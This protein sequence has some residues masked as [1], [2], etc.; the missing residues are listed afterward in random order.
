MATITADPLQFLT[1]LTV[2][3]N[4]RAVGVIRTARALTF[5]TDVGVTI[6]PAASDD[7]WS[8]VLIDR[9]TGDRVCQVPIQSLGT[10][11]ETLN[12]A[13]QIPLSLVWDGDEQSARAL[14]EINA[15]KF[16]EL[17]VRRGRRVW[18]WGVITDTDTD[19][20]TD[21]RQA[22]GPL[23]YFDHRLFGP[24]PRTN[25]IVNGDFTGRI[26][27]EIGNAGPLAGWQQKAY[28]VLGGTGTPPPGSFE[29][30][31]DPVI[32]GTNQSAHLVYN[33]GA[34]TLK[35]SQV[36]RVTAPASTDYTIA[37]SAFV[38]IDAHGNM[39]GGND[40]LE[41]TT[42]DQFTDLGGGGSGTPTTVGATVT[43]FGRWEYVFVTVTVSAGTT[44]QIEAA[45]LGFAAQN[46]TYFGRVEL[47]NETT[48]E[49]YTQMDAADLACAIVAYAQDPAKTKQDLGIGQQS[50]QTGVLLDRS[51]PDAQRDNVGGVL[52]QMC[53]GGYIDQW[54]TATS[55]ER[56]YHASARK[57]SYKPGMRL[58]STPDVHNCMVKRYTFQG[59]SGASE[60]IG[61]AGS[62]FPVDESSATN[63]DA[64]DGLLMENVY[65]AP[66][67]VDAQ[68]LFVAVD[69][70][71]RAQSSPT[72]LTVTVP[73]G[74]PH[75]DGLV[76]GDST[77]VYVLRS[78]HLQ[79]GTML[80]ILEISDRYRVTQKLTDPGSDTAEFVLDVWGGDPS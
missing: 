16:P 14:A 15:R 27:D 44:M 13:E 64:F 30:V 68:D 52:A 54:I 31:T 53:S 38:R 39:G 78:Q 48:G 9:P 65:T 23:A 26:G 67:E 36:V 42:G 51:F 40:A 49:I 20:A 79:D 61:Q 2:N 50:E 71:I 10:I 37:L 77:D 8:A 32:P 5:E 21:R 45:L 62:G 17:Q 33:S 19:L 3:V 4:A 60:V 34:F 59:S 11:T 63:L 28:G 46:D 6:A 41:I 56:T 18:S 25:L 57:G 72:Q 55:A 70:Q 43:A 80:T 76:L 66:P 69:E 22:L 7:V 75:I 58:I 29:V 1:D 73:A 24:V 47:L 12:A 74:A 35:L